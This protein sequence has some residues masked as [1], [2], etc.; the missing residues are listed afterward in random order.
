MLE[1]P[2]F[3][4]LRK[5]PWKDLDP[6]M[7]VVGGVKVNNGLPIEL[8]T[9]P[10]LSVTLIRELTSK[11]H[12]LPNREVI[13]AEANRGESP[14]R[15][16]M[17]F[18]TIEKRLKQF[19]DFRE[20][21][22]KQRNALVETKRLLL[23]PDAPLISTPYVN[24][25]HLIK[26][27]YNSFELKI[28]STNAPSM[29]S[30]L[31]EKVTLGDVLSG[32]LKDKFRLPEDVEVMLHLVVDY[33]YSM[34]TMDKLD[35]V[36]AAVN[37][38]Y[39]H[40]S[41][42]MLNVKLQLY[43]FSEN[44]VQ[45]KFPLSGKEIERKATNYGSFMKKVLHHRNPD[46]IN[47]VILFTDGEP[48]DKTDAIMTGNKMK[49]LKIDYTQIIFDINEDRRVEYQGLNGSE[50]SLDGFLTNPPP[51]IT[52]VRLNDADWRNRKAEIY[53]IFTEVAHACG[54]NQIIISVYELMSLISVEVYDRYMGRL[55][56]SRLPIITPQF[57]EFK[58][59]PKNSKEELKEQIKQKVIKP[60][61]FKK[62]ERPK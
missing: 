12:F 31:A 26:D 55:T 34:N 8:A 57:Q 32:K 14:S 4:S 43:V 59:T 7:I 16:S 30:H 39:T 53:E 3:K 35:I 58:S 21:I 62:V 13:V 60:F 6:G 40:I 23:P 51:G 46:V 27:I 52:S 24:S 45:A 37:L 33:S 11:Y 10:A 1:I 17:G 19:N 50:K 41:E 44:C 48:S 25:D 18:R 42:C 54:G 56:L 47:K 2:G 36:M 49:K 61:E 22:Q 15:M 20:V 28:P 29:F 38:F 5:I 9:F